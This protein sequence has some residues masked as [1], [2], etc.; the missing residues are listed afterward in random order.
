MFVHV[1]G[2][3]DGGT[4]RV[5]CVGA[6]VIPSLPEPAT[7]RYHVD[8]LGELVESLH[9]GQN[10]EKEQHVVL[11]E[12]LPHLPPPRSCTTRPF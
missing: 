4:G 6:T 3:V 7:V 2:G 12:T 8:D 1:G 11:S 9:C 10:F 5:P